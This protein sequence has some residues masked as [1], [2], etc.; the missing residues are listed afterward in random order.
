MIPEFMIVDPSIDLSG[1][2]QMTVADAGSGGAGVSTTG[3]TTRW[4]P[5]LPGFG[6]RCHP[7]GKRV[8]IVQTRMRGRLRTVSL[9]SAS[10]ITEFEARK[11]A[12]HV[13]LRAQ[14]GGDPAEDRQAARSAPTF[15]AYLDDYWRRASPQ[16]KPSTRRTHDVYRRGYLDGAFK[17]KTIDEITKPD[18]LGWFNQVTDRGGPGGANRVHSILNAMFAKAEA[19]GHRPEASNPCRGIRLNRRR[20]ME[21]FL[22]VQELARLGEALEEGRADY[23]DHTAAVLLILFTGCRVS[24]ILGL[25]WSDIRGHRLHLRDSKTGPRTVWIGA[26]GRAVIEGI[27]RRRKVEWVFFN[28]STGRPIGELKSYWARVRARTGFS[29]LRLHDLRHTYASHA[30]AL[31]ETLPMI[32]KLL[33]HAEVRSTARYTH[34]DDADVLRTAEKVGG[35]IAV[36]IGEIVSAGCDRAQA[37]HKGM[38]AKAT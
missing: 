25:R 15:D 30:A 23:P 3:R 4:F 22:S 33:G 26:E 9:G 37:R 7:G 2:E 21:R 11:L 36:L 27:V 6:L 1:D 17:G 20:K 34:L 5:D 19:W 8:Y 29:T 10:L 13:L 31:S 24:E 12:R 14:T 38:T 18:V 35:A 16:W 28:W 32:G